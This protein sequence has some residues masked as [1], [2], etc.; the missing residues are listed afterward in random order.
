MCEGRYTDGRML[1]RIWHKHSLETTC[2]NHSEVAP[3][4]EYH[5]TVGM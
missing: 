3:V 1:L 4:L 5:S 2:F